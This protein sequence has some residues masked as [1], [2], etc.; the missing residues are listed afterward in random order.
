M[1]RKVYILLSF[2]LITKVCFSQKTEEKEFDII[3]A[4]LYYPQTPNVRKIKIAL[5]VQKFKFPEAWLEGAYHVPFLNVLGRV[6]LKKNFTAHFSLGTVVLSNQLALGFKWNRQFD[7]KFSFN[8]GYDIA[9]VYGSFSLADFDSEVGAIVH[10]P[11]FA[12]G[13]RY[14][15]VA[16]T[17]K[18]ELSVVGHATIRNGENVI[19]DDEDF[20]NG[21]SVGIYMEQ[22]LW[23]NNVVIFGLRNHYN[24]FNYIAWPAFSTFN[25]FY[26]TPELSIGLIL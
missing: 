19:S 8:I 3:R 21:F 13:Y 12:F 6:G 15:D 16:F 5:L 17:I 22:R 23:K 25:R 26:H 11:N 20:Y 14:K 24:K 9:G 4:S 2:L 7:D 18:T 10:Y 1:E